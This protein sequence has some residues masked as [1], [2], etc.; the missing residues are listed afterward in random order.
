MIKRKQIFILVLL[1]V[2][3]LTIS[4][5]S[6]NISNITDNTV[7]NIIINEEDMN[8][9]TELDDLSTASF[10][11]E[12]NN[13]ENQ[14]E[15]DTNG[16]VMSEDSYSCG[17]ASFA[18]VLNN[19]GKNISLNEAKQATNTTIDGTSMDNIVNAAK[20]YDLTAYALNINTNNLKENYIVH[21]NI[22]GVNHWSV[23][24]TVTNESIILADPNL[25]NYE[26]N[27]LEFNQYYTNQTIIITKS[28]INNIVNVVIPIESNFI[29]DVDQKYISGKGYDYYISKT[30]GYVDVNPKGP[31]IRYTIIVPK[32]GGKTVKLSTTKLTKHKISTKVV[33][34]ITVY[35]KKNFKGKSKTFY[36]PE[37]FNFAHKS[38]Y[39]YPVTRK[40]SFP[41]HSIKW[42][43]QMYP[44]PYS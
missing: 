17:A 30:L 39:N 7:N 44:F 40:V 25:G 31:V 3:F 38:G 22:V 16:V 28:S 21:M 27:L 36:Q 9:N 33:Y 1:S 4:A 15:L 35:S 29:S 42:H 19:L 32:W 18:T 24:K 41:I 13:L 43:V 2:L 8:I 12:S 34:T 20:K 14:A 37:F 23:V 5:V 10:E 6:A 11:Y 26:Y